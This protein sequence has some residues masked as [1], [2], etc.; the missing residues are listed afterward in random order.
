MGDSSWSL[1]C[2]SSCSCAPCGV[3]D[4]ESSGPTTVA[5][6]NAGN[7]P[8]D[9]IGPDAVVCDTA[10]NDVSCPDT[11]ACRNAGDDPI[12]A[13]GPDTIDA[14]SGAG[15]D[16]WTVQPDRQPRAV[17]TTIQAAINIRSP[18]MSHQFRH[19]ARPDDSM[20]SFARGNLQCLV[21]LRLR[22]VPDDR[23]Q[24]LFRGQGPVEVGRALGGAIRMFDGDHLGVVLASEVALAE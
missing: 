10:G 19:D 12:D 15:M 18:F 11:V 23:E 9:P 13:I 2:E 14:G 17:A 21:R 20:F 8:I 5:C 4:S 3:A 16:T 6:G 22:R 1:V 24:T 7:D